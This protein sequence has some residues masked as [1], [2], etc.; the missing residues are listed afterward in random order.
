MKKLIIKICVFICLPV[1][2]LG[3]T[4]EEIKTIQA[5]TNV[6]FLLESGQALIDK[7]TKDMELAIEYAKQKGWPLTKSGKD[8]EFSMLVGITKEFEPIYIT[9]LNRGA[10]ITTRANKLYSGGGLGLDIHGESMTAAMWDAPDVLL[11]HELFENRAIKMDPLRP[12]IQNHPTHVA[13]TII[14]SDQFQDGRARGIAFKANLHAYDWI[15]DKGEARIAAG[16]GLLISNHSYGT[17]SLENFGIWGAYDNSCT[18]WDTTMYNAP[19]Y[20]AVWA[21]GNGG[22]WNGQPVEAIRLINETTN[23][24]GISIGNINGIDNYTG[25]ESVVIGIS[26]SRGPTYDGRIKPDVC[27]KGEAV[28]SSYNHTITGSHYGYAWG[29]SMAAP[30]AT[31]TLLLLQQYYKTVSGTTFMKAA[32]LK[33]LAIHTADE[34]GLY[35]GPDYKFGWGVINAEKAAL[36]IGDNSGNSVITEASLLNNAVYSKTITAVGYQPVEATL[37]WTDVPGPAIQPPYTDMSSRLVNDLDIRIT[38]EGNTYYPWKLNPANLQGAAIQG[39]NDRDNVEKIEIPNPHPG[40]VFTITI[41]HKG[42]LNAA[43]GGSKQDFSLI[44]SVGNEACLYDITITGNYSTPITESGTW[45]RSEGQ[46]TISE[47]SSVKL[48]AN[49]MS[50]YIEFKPASATDFLNAEPTTGEF[51]AEPFDGCGYSIPTVAARAPA[52]KRPVKYF[53][54]QA[55]PVTIVKEGAGYTISPNPSKGVFMLRSS[56]EI[57]N[58]T[59]VIYD[60]NG[61]KQPAAVYHTDK[62]NVRIEMRNNSKGMY[63]IRFISGNK[64]ESGKIIVL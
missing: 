62:F 13:G 55:N 11:S 63:F 32:S 6:K 25:P 23:K 31:G 58:G 42:T 40:Q 12:G 49:G 20:L 14:G 1:S 64:I 26:S 3:Q 56:T 18:I 24:N 44:I 9:T 61:K 21:A 5:G 34:A 45:I 36:I 29:T 52:Q 19:Y 51:I 54:K 38:S 46:T 15:N 22:D 17:S 60:V 37:C 50:G 30:G 4:E 59:V 47:A 2:L 28:F 33:G 43:M 35:P 8:G 57:H 27:S 7:Q 16:N 41:T 39:D 53:P 10:G 48:D